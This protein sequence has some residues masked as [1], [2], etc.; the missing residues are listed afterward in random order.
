MFFLRPWNYVEM[1]NEHG[2]GCR[3]SVLVGISSCIFKW[4]D[5]S[6][7]TLFS[8]PQPPK[9][10]SKTFY[11]GSQGIPTHP[12]LRGQHC[13]VSLKWQIKFGDF[14][15]SWL[16]A[17]FSLEYE[18]KYILFYLVYEVFN[19]VKFF[20]LY[21][22]ELLFIYIYIYIYIIYQFGTICL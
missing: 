2:V 11:L 14:S 12:C 6:L 15:K 16:T 21:T 22:A 5:C 10:G 1:D 18:I 3:F 17:V 4:F 20:S 9:R 8:Y 7:S 19:F 13:Q